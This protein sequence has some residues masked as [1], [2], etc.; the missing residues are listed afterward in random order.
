MGKKDRRGGVR[1]R[2][3]GVE[4]DETEEWIGISGMSCRT[5][6]RKGRGA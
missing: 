1:D 5:R 3:G 2:N 6:S 4:R